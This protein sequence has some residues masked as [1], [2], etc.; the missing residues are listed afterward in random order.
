[1]SLS[2]IIYDSFMFPLENIF[3]KN[4]R[5]HMLSDVGGR[6]LEIGAGTGANLEYYDFSKIDGYSV[7][8]RRVSSKIKKYEFPGNIDL[9]FL[10]SSVERL[11][12][13]D[14]TFDNVVFT[15]VF[16]SVEDPMSGLE[17]VRRVLKPGGRIHFMEHVMPEHGFFRNI[18]NKLN[19]TWNKLANGCNLNRET[20]DMIR[21]AGFEI[22]KIERFFG[23]FIYGTAIARK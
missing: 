12:F 19:S 7:V 23:A 8:D 20:A 17:E 2:D 9:E 21:D 11:L 3:L 10:D 4:R 18:F 16:C 1:M 15:L 5:K 6:I 13:D 22:E 14:E